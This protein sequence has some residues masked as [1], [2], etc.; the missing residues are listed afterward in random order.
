MGD[1]NRR[2]LESVVLDTLG[3]YPS[4]LAA[5]DNYPEYASIA[6]TETQQFLRAPD[7]IPT[8]KPLAESA[9]SLVRPAV[10]NETHVTQLG[11]TLEFFSF[12]VFRLGIAI[13]ACR[14]ALDGTR[15]CAAHASTTTATS[16]TRSELPAHTKQGISHTL[17]QNPHITLHHPDDV[18][19][20]REALYRR[21]ERELE[22]PNIN[23]IFR[24][25][26][27]EPDLLEAVIDTQVAFTHRN[28][29][30][31][32]A[33]HRLFANALTQ[34]QIDLPN[35]RVALRAHGYGND[36]I[37]VV[38]ARIRAYQQN[39]STLV[40]TLLIADLLASK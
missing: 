31:D 14:Y 34:L 9:I 5:V 28:P 30:V 21:I 23:N 40:T 27:A 2:T 16:G 22:T 24:G 26:A 1:E 17:P 37:D 10:N 20:R 33:I 29:G 11:E 8:A 12:V 18:S 13:T 39:L 6:W 36:D 3:F 15:T 4:Y 35:H 38:A 32:A 25:L 7:A 19:G